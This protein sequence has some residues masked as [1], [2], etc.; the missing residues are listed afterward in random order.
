MQPRRRVESPAW[1]RHSASPSPPASRDCRPRSQCRSRS[2]VASLPSSP[3]WRARPLVLVAVG[4]FDNFVAL[5]VGLGGLAVATMAMY[6]ALVSRRTIRWVAATASLVLVLVVVF[7]LVVSAE[8][9]RAV[10]L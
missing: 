10:L 7:D 2:V 9:I 1:S 4:L 3:C 8:P 5:V 6:V